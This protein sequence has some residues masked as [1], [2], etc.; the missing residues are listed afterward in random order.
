MG[1][2]SISQRLSSTKDAAIK[3]KIASDWAANWNKEQTELIY[4]LGQAV[5][6]NDFDQLC[7]ITGQLKAVSEKRLRSEERR[8]GKEC[9]L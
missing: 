1:R 5:K 2:K 8:V 7:I 3:T 9:R 4:D 6:D